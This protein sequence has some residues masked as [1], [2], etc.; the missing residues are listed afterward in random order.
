M[1]HDLL[2]ILLIV[3]PL[4]FL[5][6]FIDSIAGGGG[7][8]SLPAYLFAGLPAHQALATNK[9]SSTF[10]TAL[11]F[12][13]F[14]GSGKIRYKA[15]LLAVAGAL[16]GSF[17][18]A[19]LALACDEEYLKYLLFAVIPVIAAVVLVKKDFGGQDRSASVPAAR[20]A[21]ISFLA[22]SVIG[23]YDG[24]FGPGT[25]TFLILIMTGLIGFD[26]TT[27]SGNAKVVNLASNVAALA[28]FILS[29][30]VLYL[31]GIPAALSGMLGGWLGSGLAVKKGAGAIKPIFLLVLLLLFG[32][33]GID[34]FR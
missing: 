32:K 4:V 29:G 28:A 19:R 3:C 34:L 10:G 15:S 16:P 2:H 14:A 17:L 23:T 5:A 20:T 27:S 26:L 31:V 25:G 8:I 11:A 12:F 13:R 21:V 24:F 6:G 18:G 1:P 30:K 9:F 7:L 22:G 33:I